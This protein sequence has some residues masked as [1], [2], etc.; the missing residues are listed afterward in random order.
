MGKDLKKKKLSLSKDTLRLLND[1]DLQK[2]V[3]GN[4]AGSSGKTCNCDAARSN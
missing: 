2:V 3:G 4:Q 1:V